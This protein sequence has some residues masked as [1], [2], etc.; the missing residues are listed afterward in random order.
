MSKM[1]LS[2]D[3]P[4]HCVHGETYVFSKSNYRINKTKNFLPPLLFFF[5]SE[6]DKERMEKKGSINR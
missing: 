4:I 3:V 5:L 2:D 1:S 6:R